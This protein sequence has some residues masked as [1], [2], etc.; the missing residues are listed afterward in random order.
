MDIME[1]H[2]SSFF[3]LYRCKIQILIKSN[4]CKIQTILDGDVQPIAVVYT[5][6]LRHLGLMCWEI[7]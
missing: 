3:Y 1:I 6:I 4:Q 5:V 7:D 2:L